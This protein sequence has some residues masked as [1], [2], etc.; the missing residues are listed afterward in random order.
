MNGSSSPTSSTSNV[1]FDT[2]RSR[3]SSKILVGRYRLSSSNQKVDYVYIPSQLLSSDN[4]TFDDTW[5]ALNLQ[6][7]KLCFYVNGAPPP[8]EWNFQLPPYKKDLI[9]QKGKALELYHG[10]LEANCKRLLKGTASACS[11]A[12]AVYRIDPRWNPT[13]R[14]N[15]LGD[16]LY[17]T[18]SQVPIMSISDTKNFDAGITKQLIDNARQYNSTLTLEERLQFPTI[19]LD[20]APFYHGPKSGYDED[21][22]ISTF[23]QP[24]TTHLIFSDDFEHLEKQFEDGSN[25]GVPHG[26]IVV[27][28]GPM[29]TQGVVDGIMEHKPIFLF[30]YTGESADLAIEMLLKAET[31]MKKRARKPQARPEQPFKSEYPPG[32]THKDWHS[33]WG[34]STF[35]SC[36]S[37][38]I[39]IENFPESYKPSLVLQIDM[40]N[41]TE[42]KLQ[43]SLTKTMVTAFESSS[44]LGGQM[45]ETRRL[46]YAWRLRQILNYNAQKQKLLADFFQLLIIVGT[47]VAICVSVIFMHLSLQPTCDIDC[48][49]AK[50]VLLICNLLIPLFVTI[51]RGVNSAMNPYKKWNTLKSSALSIESEIYKYRCKVLSYAASRAAT[52]SMS[53]Q[54][55]PAGKKEEEKQ[56]VKKD[57]KRAF[58]DFLDS[59]WQDLT[60]SEIS[61][62]ALSYP[63]EGSDP[64]EDIN[65]R[66]NSNFGLQE[67]Y[68][69]VMKVQKSDKSEPN[70]AEKGFGNKE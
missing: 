25:V 8:N 46:T 5:A 70:V 47:F 35:K 10:V 39:L 6:P 2:K 9:G 58:S 23:P 18:R 15:A 52:S 40:F 30:K 42:E 7:P 20:T 49:K 62:G 32:Y 65:D 67:S 63:P 14:L 68:H 61:K 34:E 36:K 53:A 17:D 64:L 60:A 43:D 31:F 69:A 54:S 22:E 48:E 57:Q 44:E 56:V 59:V 24:A 19:V 26:L 12:S 33:S 45:A 16:W 4:F 37:L 13:E 11:Q 66:Y 27:N 28:G 29:T 38:N 1:T 55:A 50:N 21:G 51:I 41:T 3:G